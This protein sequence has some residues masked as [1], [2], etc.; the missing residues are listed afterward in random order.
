VL[1]PILVELGVI[2]LHREDDLCIPSWWELWKSVKQLLPDRSDTSFASPLIIKQKK[3]AI[4]YA[5]VVTD[6]P[7]VPE[8]YS[9]VM[10]YNHN[11]E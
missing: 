8:G 3:A 6:S 9:L 7:K 11:N 5:K 2:A 1:Q 4:L 10:T